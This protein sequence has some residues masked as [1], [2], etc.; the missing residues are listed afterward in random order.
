MPKSRACGLVADYGAVPESLP[1]CKPRRS[2][3][4]PQ[5]AL[6]DAQRAD[7]RVYARRR[8]KAE[9]AISGAKCLG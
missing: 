8:I 9:Y 4:N 1:H 2:K 7:N 6:T 3:Q 5:M